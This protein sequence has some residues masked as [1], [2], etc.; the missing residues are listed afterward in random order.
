M[1]PDV[2]APGSMILSAKTR[3]ASITVKENFGVSTDP[4]WYFNTGTS[5]ATPLVAGCAA[6]LRQAL[7]ESKASASPSAALIKAMLI[8]GARDMGRRREEQGFGRVDLS[9]S[10]IVKGETKN[11]D[12]IEGQLTEEVGEDEVDHQFTLSKYMGDTAAKGMLKI[13]LVW[14]DVADAVL[15]HEVIL[16]VTV[17]YDNKIE[18]KSGTLN[19]PD[20]GSV[21]NAVGQVL[22]EN[23]PR[24]AIV[25]VI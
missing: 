17:N 24:D 22:W 23:L 11:R 2:V 8:N 7:I 16:R 25:T 20:G 15:Q 13:T 6:V 12:F 1:K 9:N 21:V 19:G 18:T 10:V 4:L 3:A 14:T 5:M